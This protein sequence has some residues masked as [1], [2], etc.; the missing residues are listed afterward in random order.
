MSSEGK[1]CRQRK[2]DVGGSQKPAARGSRRFAPP[3]HASNS[4]PIPSR[5]HQQPHK[6]YYFLLGLFPMLR[7]GA[8]AA[9]GRG[10]RRKRAEFQEQC[11]EHR[12]REAVCV[13]CGRMHFGGVQGLS[14]PWHLNG[15]GGSP[16][17][18]GREREMRGCGEPAQEG[19]CAV[20]GG[21]MKGTV[22]HEAM[23]IC[24]T[25]REGRTRV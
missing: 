15:R 21:N 22:L 17:W 24:R 18:R 25:V 16:G 19:A 11:K 6:H 3:P 14:T 2:C 23:S 5:M 8:F 7:V 9:A 20:M 1:C 4:N 13:K 12:G 10:R